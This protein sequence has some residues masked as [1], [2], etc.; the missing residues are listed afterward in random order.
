MILP[1]VEALAQ[2][3]FASDGRDVIKWDAMIEPQGGFVREHY[4]SLAKASIAWLADRA[5]VT[6][7]GTVTMIPPPPAVSE[8]P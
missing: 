1:D 8:R 7:F 3:L 2:L 6:V 4:R 5:P